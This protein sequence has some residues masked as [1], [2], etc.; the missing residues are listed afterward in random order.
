MYYEE[1]SPIHK[2]LFR[3]ERNKPLS[4]SI[5]YKIINDENYIYDLIDLFKEWFPFTYDRDYFR[6]YF[7][8]DDC[9]PVGAFI[10]IESFSMKMISKFS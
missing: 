6:K 10:K 1:I 9:I 2:L 8:R 3:L 7:I 4:I 5:K